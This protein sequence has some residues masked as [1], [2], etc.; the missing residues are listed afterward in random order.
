MTDQYIW[1][2][3]TFEAFLIIIP[4][5][6]KFHHTPNNHEWK[7]LKQEIFAIV[8]DKPNHSPAHKFVQGLKLPHTPLAQS[9]IIQTLNN[10]L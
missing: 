8:S 2:N 5:Q 1:K 7:P 9:K 3:G 4:R 6:L 10:K